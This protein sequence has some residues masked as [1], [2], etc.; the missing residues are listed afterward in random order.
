MELV[1][2]AGFLYWYDFI[3]VKAFQAF[4]NISMGT[5]FI[6]NNNRA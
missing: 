1:K 5:N 2:L 6:F 4:N 3:L